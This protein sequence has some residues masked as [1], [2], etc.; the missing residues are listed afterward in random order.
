ME[1]LAGSDYHSIYETCNDAFPTLGTSGTQLNNNIVY[2]GDK[3]L[4]TQE[5]SH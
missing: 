4:E 3:A 2:C 1:R 5:G